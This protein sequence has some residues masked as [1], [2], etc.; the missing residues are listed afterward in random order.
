MFI[1]QGERSAVSQVLHSK[2]D[3]DAIAAWRQDLNRIL[4]IFNVRSVNPV[5]QSLRNRLQTELLMNNHM[6]LMDIYRNALPIQ[7]G[8]DGQTPSVSMGFYPP[9]TAH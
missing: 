2:N 6:M 4:Q 5:W 3:K 1:E 9:T 7:A 8:S